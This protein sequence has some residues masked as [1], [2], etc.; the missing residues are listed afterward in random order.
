MCISHTFHDISCIS[1]PFKVCVCVCLWLWQ[2]CMADH[3]RLRDV[4]EVM[5]R[6]GLD[7][8][9]D[10]FAH[11]AASVG[12]ETQPSCTQLLLI[13]AS[14]TRVNILQHTTCIYHTGCYQLL[15]IFWHVNRNFDFQRLLVQ[16]LI[17]AL[18]QRRGRDMSAL[19]IQLTT[20]PHGY[21]MVSRCA[22]RTSRF[23]ELVL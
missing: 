23:Q 4:S 3:G 21:S 20:Q 22:G 16:D 12:S 17:E 13:G 15:Q 10:W 5:R 18:K 9:Q 14:C 1:H 8:P 11:F 19:E 2:T 7:V 6:T